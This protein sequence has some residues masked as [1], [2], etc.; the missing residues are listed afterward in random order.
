MA[1]DTIPGFLCYPISPFLDISPGYYTVDADGEGVGWAFECP[2]TGTL[3]Q[4]A[5]GTGAVTTGDANM[6]VRLET[7]DPATGLPSGTLIDSPTNV[8]TGTVNI[9]STD[10][11]VVKSC[12]INGGTGVSVTTGD[13]IAVTIKRPA[14]GSFNGRILYGSTSFAGM[15]TGFPYY[16][17]YGITS[18]GAWT[19]ISTPG[20]IDIALNIGGWICPVGGF[21]ATSAA[22]L[23]AFASPKERGILLNFPIKMR[24]TGGIAFVTADAGEN[25]KFVLYSNPTGTPVQVAV[26]NIYDADLR[27]GTA[28]RACYFQFTTPYEMAKDTDYVLAVAPTTAGAI[29]LTV[30]RSESA[31]GALFFGGEN[32]TLW[33]REDSS[34]GVFSETNT[35]VPKIAGFFDQ[36]ED[37]AAGGGRPEIRG[38]NL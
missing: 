14:S 19:R 13:I 1:M 28:G 31:Y 23:S 17:D 24:I 7:V 27:T 30:T 29:L 37:P 25:Y 20:G 9:A 10:D 5:F 18:A 12:D 16:L 35:D 11:S 38:G 15:N 3:A 26:S 32:A 33:G 6:S 8:A 36:I 34:S 22:T 4:I 21:L 2:K